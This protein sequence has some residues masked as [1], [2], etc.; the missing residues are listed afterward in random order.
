MV[1]G[2]KGAILY[3]DADG[4]RCMETAD[5]GGESAGIGIL[6]DKRKTDGQTR[7]GRGVWSSGGAYK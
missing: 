1:K 7:S 3:A 6:R 4:R 5:V 2:W